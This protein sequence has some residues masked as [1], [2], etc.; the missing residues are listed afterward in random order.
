MALSNYTP[1]RRAATLADF[2]AIPAARRFHEILDGEL[3]VKP[4]PSAQHAHAQRKLG[5]LLDPYS[6]RAGRDAE[7]SFWIVTEAEILL[8]A[9]RQPVRPDLAAWRRARM[10]K[11]PDRFPVELVPDWVCEVVSK[12]DPRR[13]TVIKRADYAR[14][15]IPHYWLLDLRTES[16]T[17][18]KLT[19]EGYV[20][21][22]QAQRG[23]ELRAEPFAE[24]RLRVDALFGE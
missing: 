8:P 1:A 20:V 4:M 22:A 16:A 15:G 24:L 21:A 7:S 14:A 6:E 3:R 17:A 18:L 2:L 5:A 11:L 9:G 19:P 23:D 13:D 10:P 12:E